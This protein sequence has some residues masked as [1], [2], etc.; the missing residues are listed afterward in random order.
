MFY[1]FL[2]SLCQKMFIY[3]EKTPH[4][5]TF[6]LVRSFDEQ[7]INL[8]E[9]DGHETT[10]QVIRV[11]KVPSPFQVIKSIKYTW[12]ISVSTTKDTS[13]SHHFLLFYSHQLDMD[14]K[15]G[16]ARGRSSLAVGVGVERVI[17]KNIQKSFIQT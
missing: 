3:I 5:F 14:R 9:R 8:E 6:T 1:P 17:H 11:K 12:C 4:V 7:S 16:R 15:K 10:R 13:S 2:T